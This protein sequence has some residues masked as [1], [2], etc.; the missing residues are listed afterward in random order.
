M[1][2]ML[3]VCVVTALLG[4]MDSAHHHHPT[5]HP[6][7]L[8]LRTFLQLLGICLNFLVLVRTQAAAFWISWNCWMAFTGT[9]TKIFSSGDKNMG[10]V[11]SVT[12]KESRKCFWGDGRLHWWCCSCAKRNTSRFLSWAVVLGDLISTCAHTVS[13]SLS[14]L[15]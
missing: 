14:T 12:E 11:L 4:T 9:F 15:H 8:Y 6:C 3:G 7:T 10:R 13:L 1:K 5:H 2:K